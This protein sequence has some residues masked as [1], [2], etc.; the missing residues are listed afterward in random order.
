MR[1]SGSISVCVYIC[2]CVIVSEYLSAVQSKWNPGFYLCYAECYVNCFFWF[3]DIP[4]NC[5]ETRY[6]IYVF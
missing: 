1:V 5:W 2:V 3:L 6:E 4:L